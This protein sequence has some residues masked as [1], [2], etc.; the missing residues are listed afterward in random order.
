MNSATFIRE[1]KCI[2]YK[3]DNHRSL[4]LALENVRSKF[5]F[6]FQ[7]ANNMNTLHF[8]TF[9]A[10]VEVIEHHWGNI[11]SNDT[12]INLDIK[13]THPSRMRRHYMPANYPPS[14]QCYIKKALAIT[15]LKRSDKSRYGVLIDKLENQNSVRADQYP[16]NL[17]SALRT[18][19]DSYESKSNPIKLCTT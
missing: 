17:L 1:V 9:K 8:D 7:K 2:S 5:Y 11:S 3:Y 14:L 10:L 15:F 12:L 18:I 16:V 19:G 13:K 4:Y 6:Y